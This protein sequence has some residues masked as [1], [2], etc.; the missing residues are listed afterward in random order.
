[1]SD[2]T[3]TLGIELPLICGAM[4]P[5]SNAELVAAASEAGAIGI[6][7]PISLTFVHGHDFREGLRY[8]KSLTSKPFGLNVIVEKS[9]KIY[10]DRAKEWVDVA[11]EEG[12][13]F[14]VTSLGKPDWVVERAKALG[15]IVY[16]DV[17]EARFAEKA[18]AA[19]VDGLI[20]V[21][22]RA[23]GHTGKL[24]LSQL[25]EKMS[26]YNVPLVAAGGIGSETEFAAALEM[27]YAGCQLGTR[28]IA[29]TECNAA[30][31]YKK[32]IVEASER[33]IV[34]TERLSGVPV[35]VINNEYV[36][37]TGTEVDPISK[38]FLQTPATKHYARMALQVTSLFS[39]KT[40][41]QKGKA[42]D[43]Y[44]QAGKSVATIDKIEPV[45]NIVG[46]FKEAY[47]NIKED[48]LAANNA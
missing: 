20:C 29:T 43:N 22:S 35:S 1:M 48:V 41:N 37:R 23:G 12:V 19:G 21:N 24:G 27:G 9:A 7:Q 16:H 31:D 25:K 11:L 32:A 40:A 47:L 4:Y 3:K 18:L 42:Y 45:A 46:R 26:Q 15:G 17:T 2:L 30:D 28:F 39:L 33:D 36:Q 34:L 44:W 8:I 14:F 5:C 13:R 10:E 38:F 6:V